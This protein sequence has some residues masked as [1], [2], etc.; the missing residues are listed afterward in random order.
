VQDHCYAPIPAVLCVPIGVVAL[1][2]H[3]G[4]FQYSYDFTTG[5]DY[6]VRGTYAYT[7]TSATTGSLLLNLSTGWSCRHNTSGWTP[8]EGTTTTTVTLLGDGSITVTADDSSNNGTW[9]PLNTNLA[10]GPNVM[11]LMPITPDQFFGNEWDPTTGGFSGDYRWGEDMCGEAGP[12][13]AY[14]TPT[15]ARF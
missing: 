5:S 11:E 2:F 12:C 6:E 4:Q 8:N 14:C 10:G 13:N 9:V 1:Y 15:P 3:A 7:A